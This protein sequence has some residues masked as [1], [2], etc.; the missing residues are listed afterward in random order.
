MT[1]GTTPCAWAH[2]NPD[3]TQEGWRNCVGWSDSCAQR[4]CELK[5]HSQRRRKA[6][7][8]SYRSFPGTPAQQGRRA[9]IEAARAA[10]ASQTDLAALR[11]PRGH[12]QWCELEITDHKT[13]K[14]NTRRTWHSRA[15]EPNCLEQY[16]WH[17]RSP[18]Q[19]E[20][21]M[22]RDGT[23]CSGCGAEKGHWSHGGIIDPRRS[24]DR[25]PYWL[26]WYPEE[27]HVGEFHAIQLHASLE[28]DHILPLA[29]VML[30]IPE[31][32]R[33][34]YFGPRNLWG[35]CRECHLTKTRGDV[36]EI[37]EAR[38]RLTAQEPCG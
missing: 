38:A 36:R 5:A 12:C 7:A 23:K 1:W 17:T 2:A 15:D 14:P 9:A 30:T 6:E 19:L 34:R 33:W 16:Y 25:D 22:E 21:I 8:A 13:G 32:D 3:R 35:L 10:G 29:L 24:R 18:D 37:K 31:A 28:V 27:T 4:G 20:M 26:K 11:L